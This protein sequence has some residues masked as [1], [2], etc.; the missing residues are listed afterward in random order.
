MMRVGRFFTAFIL[1]LPGIPSMGAAVAVDETKLT[2]D[3]PTP[4]ALFGAS[5]AAAGETVVIGAPGANAAYVF[6]RSGTLWEQQQ[7]LD[8]SGGLGSAGFSVAIDEDTAVVGAPQENV[9]GV[10]ASGAAYVFLRSGNNWTEQ[11]RLLPEEPVA[12]AKFGTSVAVQGDTVIVGAP[13]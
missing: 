2:A 4:G 1:L 12:N 3:S 10:E 7:K 5:A 11:K 8:P 13:R 9:D 6:V